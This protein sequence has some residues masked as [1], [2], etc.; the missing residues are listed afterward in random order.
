MHGNA[1]QQRQAEEAADAAARIV[2]DPDFE[3]SCA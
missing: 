3:L 1:D 2:T